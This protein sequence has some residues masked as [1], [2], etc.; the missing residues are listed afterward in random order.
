MR[1]MKVIGVILLVLVIL[2]VVAAG[3]FAGLGLPWLDRVLAAEVRDEFDL[4]EGSRVVIKRGSLAQTFDGYVPQ[5]TVDAE[6]ASLDGLQV[7]D[8]HFEGEAIKFDLSKLA[9]ERTA[10]LE[11]A[12]RG[13]ISFK[14][15]DDALADYWRPEIEEAGLSNPT[16]E[17]DAQ[18]AK[19]SAVVDLKLAEVRLAAKG[20]FEVDG[21]RKV[22]FRVREFEAGG[23]NFNLGAFK[24]SLSKLTPILELDQFKMEIRVDE[25]STSDGYLTVRGNSIP[26]GE[27]G[28]GA[29]TPPD[30]A[31][32]DSPTGT[33]QT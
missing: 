8:M 18:G 13:E 19:V 28:A 12:Q 21:S 25:L 23:M 6:K 30:D 9:S 2:A 22:R 3:L 32:A 24:T 5:F 15:S 1:A 29:E 16:I 20:V 33:Q 31:A 27:A 4:P 26:A 17:I 7:E 10:Q 14:V 11:H